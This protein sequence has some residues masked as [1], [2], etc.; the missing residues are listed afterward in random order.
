MKF[1]KPDIT[2]LR[3]LISYA[4]VCS[5]AG[6]QPGILLEG[7]RETTQPHPDETR[8]VQN[9]QQVFPALT[10]MED[11]PQQA[12][13]IQQDT[14]EEQGSQPPDIFQKEEAAQQAEKIH[15]PAWF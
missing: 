9:G 5:I 11:R 1:F 7:K 15:Q 12:E 6:T 14:Q 3:L 10:G 4:P 13:T 8:Q 2:T